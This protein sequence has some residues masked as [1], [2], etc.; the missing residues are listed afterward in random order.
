MMMAMMM[1]VL[2]T[3]RDAGCR[4]YGGG[5]EDDEDVDAVEDGSEEDKDDNVHDEKIEKGDGDDGYGD[6]GHF[7]NDE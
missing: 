4:D 6:D 7:D 1:M 5:A 3:M 2:W